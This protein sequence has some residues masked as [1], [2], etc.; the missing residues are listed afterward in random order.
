MCDH[1]TYVHV[2]KLRRTQI[3]NT[4]YAS[5][6]WKCDVLCS[7]DSSIRYANLFSI[8]SGCKE[9]NATAEV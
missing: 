4:E 7:V 6:Y 1:L 8:A 2:C 5:Y 9:R 3:D